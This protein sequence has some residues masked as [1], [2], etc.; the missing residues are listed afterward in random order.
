MTDPPKHASGTLIQAVHS[1]FFRK[2]GVNLTGLLLGHFMHL[3]KSSCAGIREFRG[4]ECNFRT[5]CTI[6]AGENEGGLL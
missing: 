4:L 6:M 3:N 2:E 1:K 5:Y